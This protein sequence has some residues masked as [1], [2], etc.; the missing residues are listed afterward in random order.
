MLVELKDFDFTEL[1]ILSVAKDS[2][3]PED[4]QPNQHTVVTVAYHDINTKPVI[5]FDAKVISEI[6]NS[7]FGDTSKIILEVQPLNV[8]EM[9]TFSTALLKTAIK[10]CYKSNGESV[11]PNNLV[12]DYDYITLGFKPFHKD[13][14]QIVCR[15]DGIRTSKDDMKRKFNINDEVSIKAHMSIYFAKGENGAARAG[16][17]LQKMAIDHLRK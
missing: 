7:T 15:V 16:I 12:N 17:S 1:Q 9:K 2:I 4:L 3:D 6:Q 14:A 10:L 13:T 5:H 11:Y 8:E